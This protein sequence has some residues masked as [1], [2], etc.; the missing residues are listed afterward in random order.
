MPALSTSSRIAFNGLDC[1]RAIRS[2]SICCC[3]IAASTRELSAAINGQAI[4]NNIVVPIATVQRLFVLPVGA[5]IELIAGL[6]FT[7]YHA[8]LP[9]KTL[10]HDRA[11]A[12]QPSH[13]S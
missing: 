10:R 13:V 5:F 11:W 4:T 12:A 6:T 3:V 8:V 2:K 7:A 1:S 9:V